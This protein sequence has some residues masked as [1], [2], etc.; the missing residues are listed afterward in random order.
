LESLILFRK[1]E[2]LNDLPS[3]Q[4]SHDDD[5]QLAHPDQPLVSLELGLLLLKSILDIISLQESIACWRLDIFSREVAY[6]EGASI[7]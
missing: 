6:E 1:F 2:E 5:S 4:N 7:S 3:Q